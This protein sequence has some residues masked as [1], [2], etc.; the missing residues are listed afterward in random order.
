M[1]S[2]STST[3]NGINSSATDARSVASS[4]PP[5]E[6]VVR[7]LRLMKERGLSATKLAAKI[8]TSQPILSRYLAGNPREKERA[9]IEDALDAWIREQT[10][11]V[12]SRASRRVRDD[13]WV[14]TQSANRVMRSLARA[15]SAGI[16]ACVYGGPGT[17]KTRTIAEYRKQYEH[18]W[19]ATMEPAFSTTVPALEEIAA[20]VGVRNATGGARAIRNA[21]VDAMHGEGLLIIDEAQHLKPAA[22]DQIRA[23]HDATGAG[24]ALVGNES[25]FARITGGDRNSSFAQ[26]SSRVGMRTYLFRPTP[27]DVRVLVAKRWGASADPDVLAVLER[28]S[29]LPGA[30]RLVVQIMN[31]VTAAKSKKVTAETVRS[32]CDSLGIGEV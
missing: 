13:K 32:A 27:L 24:I 11:A 1:D 26:L 30:L 18:V 12:E 7:A 22:L 2:H 8:G 29:Q 23:L 31:F 6:L 10:A 5:S 20:A 16:I 15:Q 25:V 4:S 28:V 21:I 3:T 14:E 17:G 9:R 19:V